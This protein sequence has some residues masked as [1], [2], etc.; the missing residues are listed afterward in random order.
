MTHAPAATPE[1]DRK[2]ERPSPRCNPRVDAGHE[3][4]VSSEER[5]ETLYATHAGRVRAYALRR[6]SAASADDVVADTF[7][8]AWRR[9]DAVPDP[10]L[11]WL[12]GVAR[13]VLANRRRGEGRAAALHERLAHAGAGESHEGSDGDPRVWSALAELPEADQELLL[14]TAWEELTPGEIAAV[15]GLRTNTVS[16]RLHRARRRFTAAL[17]EQDRT[18]TGELEVRR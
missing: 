6:T 14:L 11:P 10:A 2:H 1:T 8:V 4:I 16:V 9:L 3:V 5:F 18:T 15:L 13:R 12:L 7:L 17:A